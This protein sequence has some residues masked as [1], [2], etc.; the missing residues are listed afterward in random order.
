MVK[1]NGTVI[2]LIILLVI[3]LIIVVAII[4]FNIRRNR[5]ITASRPSAGSFENPIWYG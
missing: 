4:L 3:V 1:I 5:N 2:V